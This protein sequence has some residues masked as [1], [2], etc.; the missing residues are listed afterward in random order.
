MC[1]R[2]IGASIEVD[3]SDAFFLDELEE[4][5]VK[6]WLKHLLETMEQSVFGCMRKAAL[7]APGEKRH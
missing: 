5:V 6:T 7:L 3:I 1:F 2:E 4:Q